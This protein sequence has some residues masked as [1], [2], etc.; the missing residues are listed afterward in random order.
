MKILRFS[1]K[2]FQVRRQDMLAVLIEQLQ[3]KKKIDQVCIP[4]TDRYHEK[5]KT[6]CHKEIVELHSISPRSVDYFCIN[7]N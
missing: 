3:F 6:L 4:D 2:R 5:K 7:Y 1:I